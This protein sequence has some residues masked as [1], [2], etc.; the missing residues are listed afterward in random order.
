MAPDTPSQPDLGPIRQFSIFVENKVG[1]LNELV[2]SLATADVHIVALCLVDTTDSTIIRIVVDYPEQAEKVLVEHNFAHD[3][4]PVVAIELQS[5]AQLKD[6]TAAL[7]AAEINIHYVYPFLFRPG[8]R[9]GL[10]VRTEAQELTTSVL[11]RHGITLLGRD[12]IAR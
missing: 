10:I 8:G 9:R 1:R 5:E 11:S 12:D 3:D 6:V 7:L 2:Q 4:V